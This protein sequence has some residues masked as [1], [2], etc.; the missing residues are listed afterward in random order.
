MLNHQSLLPLTLILLSYSPTG[1]AAPA[2]SLSSAS[3]LPKD[4]AE[5][6]VILLASVNPGVTPSLVSH[7]VMTDAA[8][9]LAVSGVPHTSHTLSTTWSVTTEALFTIEPPT[10][11]PSATLTTTSLS[12]PSYTQTAPSIPDSN[13]T[14]D[15]GTLAIPSST[16]MNDLT[17]STP[18]SRTTLI[19]PPASRTTLI[20]P[21]AS[22]TTLIIPPT[23][24]PV[25]QDAVSSSSITVSTSHSASYI[26]AQAP[27]STIITEPNPTSETRG[28]SIGTSKKARHS[29]L[30]A[31]CLTLATLSTLGVCILP[32]PTPRPRTYSP[33][34]PLPAS[35]ESLRT[36]PLAD[37]RT[38]AGS[39]SG[40]S[41]RAESYATCESRY[42]APSAR[43]VVGILTRRSDASTLGSASAD[44]LVPA[45]DLSLRSPSPPSPPGGPRTPE[46]A[47]VKFAL[48]PAPN[49]V[50]APKDAQGPCALTG[51]VGEEWN[52]ARAYGARGSAGAD[53]VCLDVNT[54]MEMETVEVGG[55]VCVLM[56][57]Y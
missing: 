34:M 38:S 50:G 9:D 25:A 40:A 44:S 42:S 2:S 6:S 18:A 13:A 8:S 20:I 54:G 52:V 33:L 17:A 23:A 35:L 7:A 19:I 51:A 5:S 32:R 31:A 39:D 26:S 43:S 14:K 12:T 22:R 57:G 21:P 47:H 4:L 28:A 48:A 36:L 15:T 49:V 56:Q 41:A 24:V 53:S 45:L 30:I 55:R 46:T 37:S 16:V 27:A 29:A 1:L 3:D 11:A 10:V